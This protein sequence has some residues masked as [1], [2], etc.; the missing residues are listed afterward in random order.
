M[1]SS[2]YSQQ[3]RPLDL[4]TQRELGA[5]YTPSPV[6][7]ALV[8][9]A[10]PTSPLPILD[11]SFGGGALLWPALRLAEQRWPGQGAKLIHGID[12]D[13]S[14][15]ASAQSLIA[16]GVPRSNFQLAD[17]LGVEPSDGTLFGAIVGNP[18][19]V[20]HHELDRASQR[21]GLKVAKDIQ[22]PL[23]ARA[24]SWAYFALHAPRFLMPGGRMAFL[25]PGSVLESDYGR[26]VTAHLERTFQ[27]LDLVRIRERL[28]PGIL[29]ESV[30]LLADGCGGGPTLAR[31]GDVSGL[32]DF[33]N[34]VKT[35]AEPQGPGI[36]LKMRKQS[37]LDFTSA[38]AWSQLITR[39]NI[40]PLANLAEVKIGVV[41][42]ANAHFVRTHVPTSKQPSDVDLVPILSKSAKIAGLTWTE[43]DH[44]QLELAG[45]QT[46]LVVVRPGEKRTQET[47]RWLSYGRRKGLHRRH[48]CRIRDP[49]YEIRPPKPPDAFLPYMKARA[50]GITLNL[51]SSLSTNA[52][53]GISW[54]NLATDQVATV[55]L[56]T[57][58]S[59]WALACEL[60]GRH[61]GG[62]VL[63][64]EPGVAGR[65]PA[66]AHPIP[67][68]VDIL[69]E[70]DAV[71]RTKDSANAL[72]DLADQRI[73]VAWMGFTN[74]EVAA[75][76]RAELVLWSARSPS[77]KDRHKA[78]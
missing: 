21:R 42:G 30:V 53:H 49:W 36:T 23:T 26:T 32:K 64:I 10:M 55:A 44:R 11:P 65:L 78:A 17:F 29:A 61:Y 56:F 28:F 46:R 76:K 25:L 47:S 60:L 24:S 2:R 7:N 20:R 37:L 13:Q 71:A 39:P 40:V 48:Q 9:W 75:L 50:P 27:S 19:Y 43:A 59:A 6:A 73:L 35:S 57:R 58:T 38:A 69:V 66:P 14:T 16:Q 63:K 62:G 72:R 45:Q 3:F 67:N 33:E 12:I 41:T 68:A 31:F 74:S 51:A 22:V 52:I 18:P 34:R 54:R 8:E 1:E 77:L 4:P 70:L 15:I 5:Y